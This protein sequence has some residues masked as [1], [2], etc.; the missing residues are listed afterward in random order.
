MSEQAK[1]FAELLN[2]GE[3]FYARLMDLYEN[4]SP[5]VDPESRFVIEAMLALAED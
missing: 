1:T 5:L 2:L 3:I 4:N